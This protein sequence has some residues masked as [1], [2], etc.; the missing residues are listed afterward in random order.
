MTLGGDFPIYSHSRNR[1][2]HPQVLQ[3]HT[4]SQQDSPVRGEDVRDHG[5]PDGV[6]AVSDGHSNMPNL[7]REL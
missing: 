7:H 3:R 5:L 4:V 6:P 1:N 2:A